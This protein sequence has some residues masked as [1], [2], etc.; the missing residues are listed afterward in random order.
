MVSSTQCK[1]AI[2]LIGYYN[3]YYSVCFI[4]TIGT[5]LFI[6]YAMDHYTWMNLLCKYSF[7]YASSVDNWDCIMNVFVMAVFMRFQYT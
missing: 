3:L 4:L 2:V 6:A 1:W 7:L 5:I